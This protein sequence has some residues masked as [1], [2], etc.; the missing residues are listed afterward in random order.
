MALV[1][2]ENVSAQ[3]QGFGALPALRQ[4]GLM[5]GLAVS[6]ALGVTIA[7]WSQ[8]PN[9]SMLYGNLSA[10]D[11][12]HVTLAL[13]DAAI[14]Y[15]LERGAGAIM[16]P[17]DKVHQARMSLATQGLPHGSDVGFELLEKDQGFGSSSF[18]QKA[19]YQ[20]ALEGELA[21]SISKL[22]VVESAR[23]HLAIPKQSAF[24]RKTAKPAVSVVLNL[25][26]GRVLDEMQVAGI[27]NMVASSV[28]ELDAENVTIIDQKGRLLNNA[29]SNAD[30]LLSSTQFDYTRKLEERYVKRIIDIIS[31]IVGM[32]GVRAQVVADV[33]FTAQEQTT[34]SYVP[35]QTVV[36]SE[37]LYE[38]STDTPAA[39]G[40]PGALSNQ[41]PPAGTTEDFQTQEA[42]AAQPIRNTSRSVRNYEV[43]RTISHTRKSPVSL[44]KLSVAV[45]VDYR[46][47]QNKE[48]ET[49]RMPLE[50]SEMERITALV[51][52]AVGLNQARGDTINVVNTPFQLP[53]EVEPLPDVPIWEQAWLLSLVKQLLGALAVLF[54]AFGVLRP[55][56]RNLSTQGKYSAAQAL[57]AGQSAGQLALGEDQL[58]LSNQSQA[59][60]KQLLEMA[61]TMAKEDPKRVAQVLN[62]WV[63]KEE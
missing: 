38:E 39:M 57:P 26:P 63:S 31:P 45:V 47:A 60:G 40:I 48:G 6:V 9:Y 13:D 34:E 22:N 46:L 2:A 4:L 62:T 19:R 55:M 12:S 51:R 59:S 36:R 33:D 20:R 24:A 44:N 14:E 27:V 58:T 3:V 7:M 37:Q 53:A 28:P 15:R 29:G 30:M 54:I 25:Y 32:D 10:K 56:L 49:E 17:A 5:V 41:P 21:Q 16:V 50:N 23:V 8:S 18:L 42:T 1:S 61:S 11:M 35:E 52:E 43:D